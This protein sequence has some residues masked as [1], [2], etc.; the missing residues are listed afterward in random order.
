MQLVKASIILEASEHQW[1]RKQTDQQLSKT[2]RLL[3]RID[4]KQCFLQV[5]VSVALPTAPSS[6][7]L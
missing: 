1:M 6:A 5:E 2:L 3:L 4:S 7:L